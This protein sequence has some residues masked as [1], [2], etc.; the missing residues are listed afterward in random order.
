MDDGFRAALFCL[1]R[2]FHLLADGNP[3]ALVDEAMEVVIRSVRRHTCHG[4]ILTTILA[5]FGEGDTQ[6]AGR[7]NRIVKKQLVEIP[8]T[9]EQKKTGIGGLQLDVARHHR[10]ERGTVAG[11]AGWH[12]RQIS[13][14]EVSGH[15]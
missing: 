7:Y 12:R 8:H 2:I 15:R 5:A 13:R 1:R 9:I 11:F 6:S 4:D 14:A 10:G 3:V